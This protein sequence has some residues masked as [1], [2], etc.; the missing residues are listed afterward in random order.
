MIV[1]FTSPSDITQNTLF[2]LQF[3]ASVGAT[4]PT[5]IPCGTTTPSMGYDPLLYCNYDSTNR[6]ILFSGFTA[7]AAGTPV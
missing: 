7:R 3:P 5:E 4:Q 1:D 2:M 6:R